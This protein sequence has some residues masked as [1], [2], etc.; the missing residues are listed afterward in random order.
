MKENG[1]VVPAD[2]TVTGITIQACSKSCFDDPSNC[3]YM[4]YKNAP[5]EYCKLY[6]SP[7]EK[8]S[9]T[10]NEATVYKQYVDC[11]AVLGLVSPPV[12][13]ISRPIAT[14]SLEL[15]NW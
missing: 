8:K 10:P 15:G 7:C 6:N 9:A 13:Q 2:Q 4:R 14:P 5:S 12:T 11:R 1:D 3:K